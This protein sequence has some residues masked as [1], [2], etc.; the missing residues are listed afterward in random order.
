MK[1]RLLRFIL[2]SL[3]FSCYIFT[4][5]AM[6]LTS[7]IA[8]DASAQL[9]SVKD[10]YISVDAK[11]ARIVEVFKDIEKKTDFKFH[12]FQQDL[13][14][15]LKLD[16]SGKR[17]AVAAILYKIAD[18]AHLKFR[19]VNYNIAVSKIENADNDAIT[20][21][22]LVPVSG[23]V[24]DENGEGLAGVNVV[25]KGTTQGTITDIEGNF[26]VEAAQGATL[27]FSFI[28]YLTKEVAVGASTVIN[29]EMEVDAKTLTEV[30]VVG[31]GESNKQKLTGSVETVGSTKFEQVPVP[32]F[33]R[34]LQG[35]VAGLNVTGTSGQPGGTANVRLRGINSINAGNAPLYVLDGVPINIGQLSRTTLSSNVLATINPN[36]IES[37]TVLKDAS[38]SAIY[39]S[40]A[41]N[42]VILITTKKG[43]PGKTKFNFRAQYGVSDWENPNNFSVMNSAQFTE[44]MREA[45]INSGADP[46]SPTPSATYFPYVQDTVDTDWFDIAFQD[47]ITESYE[48]NASGGDDKTR[49][50]IS[51]SYMDQEGIAVQTRLRRYSTRF[52]IDHSA[53][54]K[55]TF[56]INLGLSHNIQN[57]RPGGNTSFSDPIYGGHYLSP[58]YP[59]FASAE[60]IANGE[61]RGTGFNFNT[62]GFNGHNSAATIAL[63]SNE[64]T[65]GRV[66]GKV[67]ANY[68]IIPD[69]TFNTSIGLDLVEIKEDEWV[70]ANHQDG[71]NDGGQSTSISTQNLDYIITNML[72]YNRTFADLHNIT[73]LVASEYQEATRESIDVTAINFPSDRVRTVESGAENDGYGSINTEWSIWGLFSRINYNYD[74]KYFLDLSVRRDGSSRFGANNRY[75]TFWSVGGG[76]LISDEQFASGLSFV[77]NLKL[78]GSYGT[79][80][81]QSGIDNFD[82]RGLYQYGS[83][84]G[85]SAGRPSQLA[86]P[87]LTWET[88]VQ[89]NVGLDFSVLDSRLSGSFEYYRNNTKD[90]LLERQLSRTTGF[91]NIN[92]NVG[93]IQNKGFE[94]TLSSVNLTLG[95][96]EWSTDFNIAFNDSEVISLVG[97]A[98]IIDGVEIQREG[99]PVNSFFMPRW[100]GVNPAN[101]QPLWYDEDGNVVTAYGDADRVVVGQPYADFFGGLTNTF[102]YK[103]VSLSVFFFFSQGLDVYRSIGRFISSD[104]SRFGRNQSV[105]QL[106]RWQKPGD[107]TDVPI[108]KR[109]NTDGGN[110]HSTRYLEDG[111]FIRLRNVTLAYNVPSAWLSKY[112][113]E[114]VRL[115]VQGQN[116]LTFTEFNGMDPEVSI[117]G[118]DFG[119]YPQ[120][121]TW[122]IGLDIGF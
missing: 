107:V 103:G 113:L 44:Y 61:D 96:F 39:G 87:D 42:G 65:S 110:Q 4:L 93:E 31:Y 29:V 26:A 1:Y 24:T 13:N 45:I 64:T 95:G 119:L 47:G 71:L 20:I 33:D 70:S 77:D 55:L 94:A 100:A 85:Q 12:F 34:I 37:V 86:N 98:D 106:R 40:R 83:Y 21:V 14:K 97:G 116:L 22:D 36:D 58:L 48:L 117:T 76:W 79:T 105:E 78:R 114:N 92:E 99:E 49:F 53:S 60:Q 75:A 88:T 25:V 56:G 50:F 63:R 81:N 91:T 27:V 68:D 112:K 41:S 18:M 43:K 69:L 57:S 32:S 80:G 51:G 28:G 108:I 46:D 66:V 84:N 122:T 121:R 72:T 90:L 62:Q 38:A 109:N 19:Q 3:K 89:F 2:M 120:P 35:N 59:V 104:G 8:S 52:N 17:Q 5:Q 118:I 115:Y 73:A 6:S 111:S 82:S 10:V 30:V 54:E 67:Y 16:I 7:L 102:N 74:N 11:D 101:G 23:K 15:D 9:K